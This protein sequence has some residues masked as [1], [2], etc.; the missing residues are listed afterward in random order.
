MQTM[1]NIAI[2]AILVLL[3]IVFLSQF[4]QSSPEVTEIKKSFKYE[5]MVK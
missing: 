4:M 5:E 2:F 3:S 1:K